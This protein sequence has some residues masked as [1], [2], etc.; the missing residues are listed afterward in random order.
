MK[1]AS[2]AIALLVMAV[3]GFGQ[4]RQATTPPTTRPA[5]RP[6]SDAAD[7]FES[8]SADQVLDRMLKP[9]TNPSRPLEPIAEKEVQDKSSGSGA[10]KPDAPKVNVMREGTFIIDRAGRLT[11]TQNGPAEFTFDA[12]GK[13]MKD[14]PM[15][16]LPNLKLMQ[17][18]DA[19]T[20]AS[21]DLKFRVTGMVTEYRGRNYL[22]LQKVLVV[23]DVTQQ[24]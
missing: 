13:A 17:M 22:M 20:A 6:S 14:P 15:I 21:R 18:E 12:D 3:S 10:V 8:M 2:F 23:P 24:F 16:I 4:P 1:L 19:V 5:T 7:P 9:E 11:K